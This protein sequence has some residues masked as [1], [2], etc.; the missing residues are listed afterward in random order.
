MTDDEMRDRLAYVISDHG[1]PMIDDAWKLADRLL[2][3]VVGNMRRYAA[4]HLRDAADDDSEAFCG[5]V[6]VPVEQ[7]RARADEL[8]PVATTEQPTKATGEM[9]HDFRPDSG[10]WGAPGEPVLPPHR[11]DPSTGRCRCGALDHPDWGVTA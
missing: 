8:D 10:Y 11:Y 9:V 5:E 3:Y 1:V 6:A 4:L 2:P 7:L